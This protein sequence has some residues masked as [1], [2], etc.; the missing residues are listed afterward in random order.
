MHNMM[1][2]DVLR[3][4]RAQ[5]EEQQRAVVTAMAALCGQSVILGAAL[6]AKANEQG[7]VIQ[8]R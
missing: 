3:D 6:L 8:R 4:L 5:D 2:I 1:T 7:P